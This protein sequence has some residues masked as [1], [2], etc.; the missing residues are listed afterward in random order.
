MCSAKQIEK[1]I[2]NLF[3]TSPVI[4]FLLIAIFGSGLPLLPSAFKGYGVI[5]AKF[6][7]R[8]I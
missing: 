7:Q 1:N 5:Y 4:A 3:K 6:L 2:E 8:P